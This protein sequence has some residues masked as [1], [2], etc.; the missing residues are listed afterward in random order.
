MNKVTI[1]PNVKKTMDAHYITIEQAL[2]RIK[3]GKSKEAVEKIRILFSKGEEYSKSKQLLP[4]VV[5]AGLADRVEKDSH[6]GDTLRNDGCVSKHSSF[7]VLD[8]DEGDTEVLKARLSKDTYIYACWR[9]VTKGVKALVKCPPN[10]TK[11]TEYYNAFIS[12]YP[13]LD[14]TSRNI[15][16]LCFESYDPDLFINV[17]STV[18]DRTLNEEEYQLQKVNYQMPRKL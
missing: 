14:S 7:F 6:G 18:W 10:L 5:F 15:G 16:R 11:H 1:F 4:S 8:F 13:E 17:D 3:T 9:G 12:R 2:K